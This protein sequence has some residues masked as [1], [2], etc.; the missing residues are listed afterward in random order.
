VA[1]EKISRDA[2]FIGPDGTRK[3]AFDLYGIT[4]EYWYWTRREGAP[5][6]NPIEQNQA[7][8]EQL[9]TFFAG[10]HVNVLL[11][12]QASLAYYANFSESIENCGLTDS[13][14]AHQP[15]TQRSRPGHE[16]WATLD[17][18]EQRRTHFVFF[19]PPYDTAAYR[20]AYFQFS[21]G[22]GRAEIITYDRALMNHLRATAADAVNFTDF[23]AYLDQYLA[24]LNSR[25]RA[26]VERDYQKFRNFYFAHESDPAR[27]Q[28]FLAFL[29]S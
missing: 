15:L 7:V 24:T 13:H 3:P 27:E 14:I 28:Q 23:E 12:G 18:L 20:F 21:A 9:A 25:S 2:L 17:Y 22:Q 1:F 16:K 4:D 8:G 19:R 5:S 11:R 6:Y 10:Q 26:D 29:K